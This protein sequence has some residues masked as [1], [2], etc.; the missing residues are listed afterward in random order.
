MSGEP[1]SNPTLAGLF[2]PKK[3]N[4]NPIDKVLK[5]SK[6]TI[7]TGVVLLMKEKF[8][9]QVRT[10]YAEGH[11]LT[12]ISIRLNCSIHKVIYWMQKT[13]ISRRN[14]SDAAYLKY[15]PSGDPFNIKSITTLGDAK[16]FGLGV[17]IY[18]GEGD[19]KSPH[20]IRVA[21]TDS[22][23]LLSFI[24]FLTVI[25]GV[26][27]EKIHFSIVCFNDSDP[28]LVADHW[29]KVFEI[30]REKF[31]KIV[32]IPPQGKGTYKRKSEFGVCTV[33]VSNIKL[34]QWMLA[35]LNKIKY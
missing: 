35:E 4:K 27:K 28:I 6:T 5:K 12:E 10:L 18:W 15:N 30:S 34:K 14:H 16:L 19:K 8:V 25:C 11:S 2:G 13:G 33:T 22:A 29:S 1:L 7:Y 17:G 26:K 3:T 31:G 9:N 32:Q 21:N 20:S 24:K 23:I